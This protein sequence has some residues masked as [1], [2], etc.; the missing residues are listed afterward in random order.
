M[1]FCTKNIVIGVTG[2]IAAYKTP[3]LVRLLKA[4][5]VNVKVVMTQDAKQFITEL[6]LQ[7]VSGSPVHSQLLDPTTEAS[8]SHITLAKWAD[9]IVIAPA[10]AN[11]IAKLNVGIAD[12]LLSTL[13]L[14]SAAPTA[15]VP[16]MNQQMWRHIAT[17]QN[18]QQ[19]AQRGV[20]FWGP[21]EGLQACGDDGPGRM[22]EPSQ[23]MEKI[24]S[25]F[26]P[27]LLQGKKIVITA[28]PTRERLDPVRY[29]SNFSSGKM[30]YAL[31]QSARDLGAQVVLISGPTQLKPPG[32]V[33]TIAV[34]SA[35]EMHRAVFEHLPDCDVFI[36]CAAVA[37]FRAKEIATQKIKKGMLTDLKLEKNIDILQ[38]IGK[39]QDKPFLVGFA[40]ESENLI[41]NAKAKL[42]QKNLD[43]VVANDIS[44]DDSGFNSDFNCV[45]VITATKQ[46][47]FE[48]MPKRDLSEALMQLIYQQLQK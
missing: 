33:K 3:E 12:D 40:A 5:G 2:S 10:T 4:K 43:M 38:E 1:N 41:E 27:K 15:L 31:A 7:A 48:L 35:S 14:A 37:D 25:H 39:R 17:Q 36:G 18:V 6:T 30:G 26:A 34:E 13:Y 20:V 9:L 22:I 47:D 44:E 42:L 29:I 28:G 32:N 24:T 11:V 19:L 45:S 8:M 21:D 23:I 46:M 16:A